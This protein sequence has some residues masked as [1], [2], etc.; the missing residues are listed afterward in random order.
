MASKGID[1][2][3]NERAFEKVGRLIDACRS[4]RHA[5]G[6]ERAL[7]WSDALEARGL[8]SAEQAQL[9]YFRANAWSK[10]RPQHAQ[11]WR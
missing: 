8:N 6:I 11:A 4:S 2:L 9:N 1:K 3:P 5:A 7:Q 10:R